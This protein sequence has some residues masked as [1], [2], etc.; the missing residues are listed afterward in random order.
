[1]SVYEMIGLVEKYGKG[2]TDR[3]RATLLRMLERLNMRGADNATLIEECKALS[4]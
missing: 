3:E 1:M 2:L 4:K